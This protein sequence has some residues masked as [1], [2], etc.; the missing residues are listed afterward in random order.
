MFE[1][2]EL[3]HLRSDRRLARNDQRIA[4][5]LDDILDTLAKVKEKLPEDINSGNIEAVSKDIQEFLGD[6]KKEEEWLFRIEKDAAIQNNDLV[7]EISDAARQMREEQKHKLDSPEVAGSIELLEKL[8]RDVHNMINQAR[9]EAAQLRNNKEQLVKYTHII[10]LHKMALQIRSKERRL[11]KELKYSD[12]GFDR[13]DHD[14]KFIEH[15]AGNQDAAND[16]KKA[17]EL[18]YKEVMGEVQ[19]LATIEHDD[20]VLS[21][22][23]M[24]EI[25][26]ARD[27]LIKLQQMGYPQEEEQKLVEQYK[28]ISNEIQASWKEIRDIQTYLTRNS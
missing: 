8:E 7:K 14:L 5:K 12:K 10:G 18:V 17:T 15:D 20:M 2:L 13:I 27:L 11:R 25:E 26:Y 16:L 6:L 1:W 19:D 23:L 21:F 4:E 22:N 24:H 28:D 3:L 9:Q